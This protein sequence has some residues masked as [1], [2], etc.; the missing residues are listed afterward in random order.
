MLR[1]KSTPRAHATGSCH[2]LLPRSRAHARLRPPF[3]N[4]S[5][6]SCCPWPWRASCYAMTLFTKAIRPCAML[7]LTQPISMGSGLPWASMGSLGSGLPWASET[8]RRLCCALQG[9]M[10]RSMIPRWHG[11]TS[12][13]RSC[14]AHATVFAAL[15]QLLHHRFTHCAAAYQKFNY[16][17]GKICTRNSSL[18]TGTAVSVPVG[19][20]VRLRS[21]CCRLAALAGLALAGLALAGLALACTACSFGLALAWMC[22]G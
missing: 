1:Q 6:Q 14:H 13:P 5:L 15:M 4:R 9:L 20:G 19:A 2:G 18:Y 21:P 7:P 16:P 10:P 17:R 11:L 22:G 12:I 8:L 3:K